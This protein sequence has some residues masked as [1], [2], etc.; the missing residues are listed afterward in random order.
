[1]ALGFYFILSSFVYYADSTQ[2]FNWESHLINRLPPYFFWALLTPVI[3]KFALL[4]RPDKNKLPK[5]ILSLT[6]LGIVVSIF[7]RVISVTAS[8]L[9][10]LLRGLTTDGFFDIL[11]QSKFVIF[12]YLFDSF[13]TYW[14]LIIMIFT[15]EYYKKFNE[16]R[17]KTIELESRIS[18]VEL[19]ALRMQLQ[20][21]FL[22]NTLNSISAL[23]H[24]NPEA[25]DLMLTRLSDL[26]RF[27]LDKSAKQKVT[28]DEEMEF[29]SAYLEIQKIRYGDRLKIQIDIPDE[30][31]FIEVPVL[32]LQPTVENSVIHS[33]E[34][35]NEPT[36]LS[37]KSELKNNSLQIIIKDNGPGLKQN[38]VEG[39]GMQNT[40][41]RLE[42]LYGNSSEYFFENSD[43]GL[44]TKITIPIE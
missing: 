22:F 34:K 3:Y 41:I 24:K 16:N 12:S 27:T 32:I 11:I 23:I 39:I 44:S 7:H 43:H 33:L 5:N 35:R 37:I 21:H 6:L 17:L 14:V 10:F 26:L 42:Q 38:Y 4:F 8:Y 31:K 1:M 2:P 29:I 40:R 28:L 9:I 18:Q 25:A 20:P 30:T 19:K 36:E 13:F 15:I